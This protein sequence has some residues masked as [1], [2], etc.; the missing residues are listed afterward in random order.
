MLG[1]FH[2]ILIFLLLTLIIQ[3][4]GSSDTNQNDVDSELPTV[5]SGNDL[6]PN[7]SGNGLFKIKSGTVSF[8]IHATSATN[9]RPEF[10]S[11]K[12]PDG[13]EL[14]TTLGEFAWKSYGYSNLLVPISS[15]YDPKPGIWSYSA[16]NYSQLKLD[17][18][19]SDLSETPTIKVQP[20]ISGSDDITSALDIMK[21]IYS[22]NGINLEVEST[23]TLDN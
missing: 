7:S 19:T 13:N 3:S 10:N 12:D 23:I 1:L 4:C 14:L 2:S 22:T 20:Y 11:L 5:S 15:S 8:L 17:M 18:R 9:S 16:T 6:N 21:N